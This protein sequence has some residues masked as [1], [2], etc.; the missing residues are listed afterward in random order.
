MALV[1]YSDLY[2]FPTGVLAANLPVRIFPHHSNGFAPIFADQAGT[3]PLPNPGT[4]TDGGGVLT[5]YIEEGKYWVHIDSEAYLIDAGLSQEEA[6]LSTGVASGGEMN[7]ATPTSVEITALVGYVVDNNALT[8]VAPSLVKVDEPGQIVALDAGSLAR[9]VTFW[10]MDSAGNVIQQATP[11]TPQQ[12]RT[13]LGLGVSFFDT[14]AGALV[15]VQTRPVILGQPANQLVDLFDA[16]GPLSTSGNAIMP[17][18]VNLSFNKA[19]G[20]LFVRASNHFA[21]GVLTDNP[22]FSPS[23]AT[24]PAI[25]RRILRT[26]AVATPP[27]VTTLDVANYDLNGVLTPVGGGTNTSTIQRVWAFATNQATAQVAVQYGQ[28][29]YASL[30]AATAAIGLEPFIPA[31]VSILGALVGY[32]CVTR[33]ATDLSDPAQAVFVRAGKFPTP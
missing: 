6:D 17:N 18:G 33:T 1:L 23:P 12:R 13:Q 22:H 25:F 8:S 26:A 32:I 20:V 24:A 3:I 29:T 21:S 19:A 5:F 31:P 9:S 2:W 10:S 28:Q 7:L 14:V 30:A 11:A 27:A 4:S 15:E 16:I